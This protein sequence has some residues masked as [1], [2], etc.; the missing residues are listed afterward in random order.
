MLV[1]KT[2]SG[3]TT[4]WKILSSALNKLAIAGKNKFK[5]VQNFVINPKSISTDELYGNFI[6]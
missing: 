4:W 3:K 6:G 1:G 2:L 5:K